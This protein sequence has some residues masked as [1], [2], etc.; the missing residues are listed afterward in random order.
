[1]K[2]L[3]FL[4][5][6]SGRSAREFYGAGRISSA[7]NVSDNELMLGDRGRL[8]GQTR[9]AAVVCGFGTFVK[10]DAKLIDRLAERA[11]INS[12]YTI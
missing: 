5:V 11:Q 6:T 12:R 2:V 8:E 4:A 1:V 9:P 3:A 10:H 7:V